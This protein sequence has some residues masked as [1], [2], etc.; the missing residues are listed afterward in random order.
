M[1]GSADPLVV[2][3]AL[4][5]LDVVAGK[6]AE[7]LGLAKHRTQRAFNLG[8]DIVVLPE[9]AISGYVVDAELAARVAEPVNGPSITELTQIAATHGGFVVVGFCERAGDDLF[10][11][12]VVLGAQGPVLHYRKLHLFDQEK[13]VFAPGDLGLPMAETRYGVLAVC[14]CYDLRFVE[15]MRIL[16]LRGVD[17]L[18][19]PAAWVG[20]FDKSV[21]AG[22][23][24]RHAD[25][26]LVQANLNQ[27]AA[28]AVSQV[29]GASHD[30]PATLGGSVACDAYGELLAGPLSRST[31]DSAIASIDLDAVRSA[32]IRSDRIRPREDRRTDVYGL[33]YL[34]SA[35]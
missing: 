30:G 6:S 3:V 10:N 27:I 18:I 31:A 15:V 28:V 4:E 32:R 33:S 24:T 21:P 7:N 19:A 26:L 13:D 8:A 14:I 12:V 29:A 22:G 20:G 17:L 1:T 34:G 16:A 25:T 5:Q 2:K 23:A 11:S 9:L 35:R